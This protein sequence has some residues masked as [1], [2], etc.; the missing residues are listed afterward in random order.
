MLARKLL[1]CLVAST[2]I[3]VFAACTG[4]AAGPD[5]SVPPAPAY[6]ESSAEACPVTRPPDPGFVPR[7]PYPAAPP[8]KDSFWYGTPSLWTELPINGAWPQ[9]AL[10]EKFWWWSEDFD[11]RAEPNPDLVITARRLDGAA[12]PYR[13]GWTTHGW[14]ADLYEAM[15][16]GFE[17]PTTG[18]WEITGEYR[19]RRLVVVQWV[20]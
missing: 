10:G 2:T 11:A 15:L 16:V 9:L 13:T 19:G 18:C 20:P 7:K 17:L 3:A 14:S 5:V 1:G 6:I 12:P 8:M 4:S